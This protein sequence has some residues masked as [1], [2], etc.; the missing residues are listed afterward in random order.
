MLKNNS[1]NFECFNNLFFK[2]EFEFP[3]DLVIL[4]TFAP[5]GAVELDLF[6]ILIIR[7]H[8]PRSHSPRTSSKPSKK[9]KTRR[10]TNPEPLL[11]F[12]F[13]LDLEL[14]DGNLLIHDGTNETCS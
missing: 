8:N 6:R 14:S 11:N 3:Q 10:A 2:K 5:G 7:L 4:V 1:C 9:K 12:S 13:P